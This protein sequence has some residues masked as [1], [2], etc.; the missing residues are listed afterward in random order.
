MCAECPDQLRN[1]VRRAGLCSRYSFERALE[2][3]QVTAHAPA[4]VTCRLKPTA[5]VFKVLRESRS[6]VKRV[7]LGKQLAQHDA[8]RIGRCGGNTVR[9]GDQLCEANDPDHG[10]GGQT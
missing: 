1:G 5:E 2:P 7:T 4:A 9:R 8:L 6:F 3:K 10:S